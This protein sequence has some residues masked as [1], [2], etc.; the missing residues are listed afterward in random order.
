MSNARDSKGNFDD[1]CINKAH[2]QA[3]RY[4]LVGLFQIPTAEL[5]DNERSSEK[6]KQRAPVPA[7]AAPRNDLIPRKLVLGAGVGADKW[8]EEFIKCI[9][10]AT[11][12]ADIAAWDKCNKDALSSLAEG[13]D[14]VYERVCVAIETK[15]KQFKADSAAVAAAENVAAYMPDPQKDAIAATNWVGQQLNDIKTPEALEAFWTQVIEPAQSKFLPPDYEVLLSEL[16]RAEARLGIEQGG[17][18][19]EAEVHDQTRP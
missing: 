8:A 14:Q 6:P 5:D 1:K 11:S 7:R 3:R 9:G 15:L 19:E 12:P 13:F 10:T 18:D 17:A 2:T 16:R 4:F